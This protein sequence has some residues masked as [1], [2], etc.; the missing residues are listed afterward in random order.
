MVL[1][2]ARLLDEAAGEVPDVTPGKART[3]WEFALAG[4]FLEAEDFLSV[5]ALTGERALE[6]RVNERCKSPEV[7][8][9]RTRT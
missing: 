1:L 4:I 8:G 7:G 3:G 2:V 5:D 6:E 9:R